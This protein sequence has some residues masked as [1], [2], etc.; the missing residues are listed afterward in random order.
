[1]NFSVSAGQIDDGGRRLRVQPIG[2][3]TDLQQLRDLVLDNGVHD[4]TGGQRTVSASVDFAGVALDCG[5]RDVSN[6]NHAFRAEFGAT[7][8]EHRARLRRRH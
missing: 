1:M 6:F 5:Y 4:S 3:L 2:E 8:L 7:P